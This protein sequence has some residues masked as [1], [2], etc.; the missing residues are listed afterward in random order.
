[1]GMLGQVFTLT[2]FLFFTGHQGQDSTENVLG[3]SGTALWLQP[4]NA[5][6][7]AHSV[8]WKMRLSSGPGWSVILTWKNN[9]G[10][11]HASWVSNHY[12][13]RFDF[14]L[15]SLTLLI[16]AAYPQD[17]GFYFLE[18][19]YLSGAVSKTQ[20]QVLVFDHVEK[21]HLQ[22]QWSVLDRGLCQ[23]VLSCL[24]S[25]DGNVSYAW[26][27]GSELI[28]TPRNLTR[29]EL[30]VDADGLHMYTCNVSNPV[31]WA[32]H[33]VNLTQGCSSDHKQFGFVPFLVSIVVLLIILFLSTLACFCVWRRKRKQ[34][35]KWTVPEP[36]VSSAQRNV[37]GNSVATFPGEC[38]EMCEHG[39]GREA[40]VARPFLPVHVLHGG[41]QVPCQADLLAGALRGGRLPGQEGWACQ[42][43]LSPLGSLGN[44]RGALGRA[45]P[46]LLCR[47]FSQGLGH[48]GGG[49]TCQK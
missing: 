46:C 40:E 27:R 43:W 42:G 20:F 31:S 47:T 17:S 4:S 44:G 25:K 38:W 8:Q 48:Q 39:G 11:N 2:L 13:E 35:S 22:E 45:L 15:K 12:K 10:P 21:P 14:I 33:T 36:S 30:Q 19:T 29:L 1:M 26:Y 23:V 7:N 49:G 41:C 32:S 28:Q 18:V 9:F 6:P 3:L 37:P 24:V 16:K 5:K 34:S